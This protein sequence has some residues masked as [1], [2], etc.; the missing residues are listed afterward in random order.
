MC[1]YMSAMKNSSL[2]LLFPIF[3]LAL[4]ACHR[5]NSSSNDP[6]EHYGYIQ[7]EQMSFVSSDLKSSYAPSM[8][9]VKLL[10][11]P[12]SFKGD[13]KEGYE[14]KIQEWTTSKILSVNQY[15]FGDS[16]SL[17]T[18][19][20]NA[21]FNRLQITGKVTNIYENT[22][23]SVES[24]LQDDTMETLFDLIEDAI[25]YIH[26]NDTD[27]DWSQYDL[28]HD[29]C[30]DNIH[31]ITDYCSG[32]NEWNTNLWPHMFWTGRKG[33]I[34]KPLANVYSISGTSF[35]NDPITAIHEQGHIFGLEDYYDYSNNGQSKIDYTGQLDMQSHNSFDW[36]SF[37]KL[38]MGWV[39]PYVI[40]GESE[41]VTLKLKAAS[42]NGDCLIIPADYSTWNGSAFDE[43][44]LLELFAPYGN[45]KK[46]WNANRAS[47]G[48]TPGVRLYHVDARTYG[49]N[50]TVIDNNQLLVVPDDQMA[51]HEINS[52]ED[53]EKWTYITKGANN[54][55]DWTAYE[56]GI[57]QLKDHPLLTIIQRGKVFTFAGDDASRHTLNASD[58]F[59]AGHKFTF[60]D[61]SHFLNKKVINQS[62]MDNGEIFPYTISIDSIEEDSCI[63]TVTKVK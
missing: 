58:L 51:E 20:L 50:E 28:N 54:S 41:K 38:S 22:T 13:T 11:V 26:D 48:N 5:G 14:D 12:I 23:I 31:L 10:V 25:N 62:T 17:S 47:L 36:N 43:Y 18:Y 30:I 60:E 7:A 3:I 1:Y 6:E 15:Y 46:D 34:E 21:S 49:S 61:Y 42:I 63:I 29:G 59:K 35:V 9:S 56:G 55:S 57:E 27:I 8:G 53:V 24:I 39:K 52:A 40:T 33:T 2:K 32:K 4:T 44:F 16:N 37:S 19:Y 45:N